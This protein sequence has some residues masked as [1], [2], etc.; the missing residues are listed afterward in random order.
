MTSVGRVDVEGESKKEEWNDE[1]TPS[2]S[3]TV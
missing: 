2:A 1:T 3:L